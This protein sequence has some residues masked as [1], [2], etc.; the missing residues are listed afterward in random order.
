MN[1]IK[2]TMAA[3]A[4]WVTPVLVATATPSIAQ[5][6]KDPCI[7]WGELAA[8]IMELRQE[9]VNMGSAMGVTDNELARM[10]VIAAYETPRF[11]TED[12]KQ[13]A[14]QDFANEVMT[15]CYKETN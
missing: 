13:Q 12:Y 10:L 4:L 5:E 1:T 9:G 6:T 14:I 3:M 8:T 2:A 15:I 11:S 7:I